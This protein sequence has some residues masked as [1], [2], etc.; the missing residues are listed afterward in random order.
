MYHLLF[1]FTPDA[2]LYDCYLLGDHKN[3]DWFYSSELS[4]SSS[5]KLTFL[6][7]EVY[8][9]FFHWTFEVGGRLAKMPQLAAHYLCLTMNG[10]RTGSNFPF[11]TAFPPCTRLSVPQSRCW[12]SCDWR[13]FFP[14]VCPGHVPNSS[15]HWRCTR[16]INA[17]S[18]MVTVEKLSVSTNENHSVLPYK[19][20]QKEHSHSWE[21]QKNMCFSGGMSAT[22]SPPLLPIT[23]A[24]WPL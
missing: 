10:I 11:A 9:F 18:N 17:M 16:R 13:G 23:V 2:R 19:K 24:S 22:L 15:A 4:S 14:S 5:G 21:E 12:V 8:L 20:S 6:T 7:K 1:A 3:H